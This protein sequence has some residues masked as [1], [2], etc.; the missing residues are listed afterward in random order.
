MR[1]LFPSDDKDERDQDHT[2]V[3]E[4]HEIKAIFSLPQFVSG[5]GE[6]NK[7]GRFHQ[8]CLIT[9]GCLCLL[10]TGA[11]VNELAQLRLD[12]IQEDDG[13]YF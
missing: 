1:K 9:I 10:M 13:V 11:R 3:F 4:P 12:D 2:D 7:Q 8:Y 6:R 5:T